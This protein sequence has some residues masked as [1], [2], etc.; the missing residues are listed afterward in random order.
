LHWVF[1][2]AVLAVSAGFGA[3]AGGYVVFAD[4]MEKSC[5][6]QFDGLIGFA[7]LVDQQGEFYS[8]FFPEGLCVMR[9]AQAYGGQ[10]GSFIAECR[11]KF[12]QLRD[13]LAAEDSA[14]MTQE[15]QDY[16]M[17]RPQGAE[18]NVMSVA[19]GQGDV[20]EAG[21]IGLI[22]GDFI[23][24]V[25]WLVVKDTCLKPIHPVRCRSG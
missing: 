9:I 19:I 4:Q 10:P 5:L 13:V 23:F 25:G 14:V 8:G 24:G 3:F 18:A 22:H 17:V 20:G 7:A 1:A 6:F 12:A 16:G 2:Q 21:A 11:L 15:D